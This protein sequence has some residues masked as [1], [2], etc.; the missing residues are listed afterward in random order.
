MLTKGDN[1]GGG[2]GDTDEPNELVGDLF[3]EF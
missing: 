3:Y 1:L 2:G